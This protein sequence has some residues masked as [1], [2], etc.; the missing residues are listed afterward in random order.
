[1]GKQ[2]ELVEFSRAAILFRPLSA[3]LSSK[4][5]SRSHLDVEHEVMDAIAK[6]KN[7]VSIE[8]SIK[9][10]EEKRKLIGKQNRNT[11]EWHPASL[12]CKR[13]NVP[14]PYPNAPDVSESQKSK[15]LFDHLSFENR[16]A[17]EKNNYQIQ[18]LKLL[19][20]NS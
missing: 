17:E 8:G 3:A 14:N 5:E 10:T 7:F 1:M 12:L 11:F 13:F 4:F 15:S 20:L 19:K 16:E 9:K 18:N 2:Q 6:A